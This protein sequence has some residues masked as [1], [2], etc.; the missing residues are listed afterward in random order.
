MVSAN[1]ADKA[2]FVR[3]F[4]RAFVDP[5]A[6]QFGVVFSPSQFVIGL[7][8]TNWAA[9]TGYIPPASIISGIT[10]LK[11]LGMSIYKYVCL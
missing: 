5:T 1:M 10:Q 6:S 9:G 2:A 4:Y 8:A 3:E 7:P 11:A